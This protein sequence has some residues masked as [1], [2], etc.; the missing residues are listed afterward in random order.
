MKPSLSQNRKASRRL[1]DR[2][3][4]RSWWVIGEGVG[5]KRRFLVQKSFEP[6]TVATPERVA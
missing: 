2:G 1:M 4:G 5:L 3:S 6:K